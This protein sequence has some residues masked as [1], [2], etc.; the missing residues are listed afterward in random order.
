MLLFVLSRSMRAL[1]TVF[2]SSLLAFIILRAMPA[3]PVSLIVGPFANEE[4]IRNL[5]ED[6]G[7]DLPL[8]VQYLTYVRDFFQGDWGFSYS[9]GRPVRDHMLAL[10]PASAELALSAFLIAVLGATIIVIITRFLNNGPIDVIIRLF[11]LLGIGIPQFWLSLILLI[12]FFE[13]LGMLPGPTGRGAEPANLITGLHSVD[14]LINGQW[15][16]L[17]DNL[18]SLLLPS[19]ALALAPM[20]YL[21]RLLRANIMDVEQ[22]GFVTVLHAKGVAPLSIYGLHILPNAFLPTLTAA[23]LILAQLI[24]GSV[25]VEGV[26]SWPGVGK[27]V[28]DSVLRQDFAVVQAFILLSAVVYIAVNLLVDICYGLIDPRVRVS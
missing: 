27:Y 20:G 21:I 25:L 11:A 23:G 5:T 3:D 16:I 24:G 2:S 8:H 19:I 6:L 7:L 17:A 13:Y 15:G 1:V 22:E 10:L 4:T 18:R 12:V 9:V 14:A 28:I 26:F